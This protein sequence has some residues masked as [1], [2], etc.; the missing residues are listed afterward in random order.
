MRKTLFFSLKTDSGDRVL[1]CRLCPRHCVLSPG[2]FG[3]CRVRQNINGQGDLPYYGFITAMAE[4]P[5]EKKPLYHFRP[6]S[7]IL[8]LGF[9]GCNLRCPFCQNWHISQ[10]TD[11]PGRRLSPTEIL[12][13][14]RKGGF[15]Q[16]AY[17]YSEPL[18]HIE[19]LLDCM[20]LCR[21]EGIANILVS[22]G[23]INTEAAAEILPLTDAANIDL[24]CFS[25]ETYAKVLGGKLRTVLE[26]IKTAYSSG[27]HLEVTTLIIP[28]LNDGAEETRLCAE[29]LSGFSRE[30]PWHLSAY[31]PDYQWNAPPTNPVSLAEIAHMGRE[32]L[33]F[34]YTG[35]IWGEH[36]DTVCQ[37]CGA[38]LINRQGYRVDSGG[39]VL[40]DVESGKQYYCA[41]CGKA[42][43]VRY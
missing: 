31:H 29:F 2:S 10:G 26:F 43:P 16:I 8:S 21:E 3:Q 32:Y 25:E 9:A 12:S 24:K 28:G 17:T 5:I 42:A 30:I 13:R 18:I 22:N 11:A 38:V 14:A 40:R 20:T 33:S 23:C 34:V 35:N 6:G 7:S 36:N 39:L 4:D 1:E 27:I 19:F 41:Q 15:T 37:H